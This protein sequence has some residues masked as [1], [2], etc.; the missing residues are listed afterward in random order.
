[1]CCRRS[2]DGGSSENVRNTDRGGLIFTHRMG[3][4]RSQVNGP[5][6]EVFIQHSDVGFSD[7]E[8]IYFNILFLYVRPCVALQERAKGI[9]LHIFL[10][11]SLLALSLDDLALHK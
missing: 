8:T 2:A 9:F 3:R 7:A 6:T 4:H 10:D 5:Y 11:L 1:M